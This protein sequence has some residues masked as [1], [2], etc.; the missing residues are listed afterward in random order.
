MFSLRMEW[1]LD[2]PG[3]RRML[4]ELIK[5][6][7]RKSQGKEQENDLNANMIDWAKTTAFIQSGIGLRINVVG[8]EPQGF[9]K[10]TDY[11]STRRMIAKQF[12]EFKDPENGENVF[13]HALPKEELLSGP[14]LEDA[15]DI[16]CLPNTGYL[17][18]EALTSFDPLAFAASSKSLFSRSTLWCGTHSPRGCVAISG[19]GVAKS[20]I[21]G[22]RLIDVAPTLL[23][24]MGLPIPRDVDGR[25]LSEAFSMEYAKTNPITWESEDLLTESAPRALSQEEE[26]RIEERLKALG[27]LS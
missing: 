26:S 21:T 22:A 19:P 25:V 23:F 17:P 15:P 10:M 3:S 14:H 12:A 20:K 1:L 7:A 9:V 27:Y 4:A 6:R 2:V 8:R 5:Y 13:E 11:D 16:L 18:T 24:M